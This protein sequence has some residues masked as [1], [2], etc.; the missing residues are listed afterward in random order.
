MGGLQEEHAAYAKQHPL[1]WL[2]KARRPPPRG[3]CGMPRCDALGRR[4]WARAAQ[5]IEDFY[6]KRYAEDV[7][8]LETRCARLAHAARG[9]R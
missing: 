4:C 5:V 8:E 6:D 9:V 2:L 3:W 7:Q 1:P